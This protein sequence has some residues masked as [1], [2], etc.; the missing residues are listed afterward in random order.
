MKK[1]FIQL[2]VCGLLTLLLAGCGGKSREEENNPKELLYGIVPSEDGEQT[3]K[4][5]DAI[6]KY[7][8][9]TLNMPVKCI[10]ISNSSALIEA[11]RARKI[12]FASG[13]AFTYLVAAEKANAEP[14]IT[15]TATDQKIR[16]KRSCLVTYS[17]SSITIADLIKIPKKY[18]L[19]WAYPTSTTG[20][21]VPR[22]FL[23]QN[24]V[25][26]HHFKEV[27]TSTDHF[28]TVLT[29][30]SRKVDVAAI[31]YPTLLKFIRTKRIKEG[32]VKVIWES[33]PVAHA[34][35]FVRK[36][37]NEVLKKR[38]QQAYLR[39]KQDSPETYQVL[40]SQYEFDIEYVPASDTLYQ[41][42][43]EMANQIEG[44]KLE[45]E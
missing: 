14:I 42:L 28:A 39:L 36:D 4:R 1:W 20:H 9:R 33:G 17:G 31:Y 38:I 5:M 30:A 8:T 19:T 25:M 24:G 11:M 2:G 10:Q 13:G 16:Q 18:T 7:F 6:T 3:L 43:R 45:P 12:H 29:V 41:P 44:L 26:P 21:L 22:Y 15:T 34:P 32:A 35:V 23:Q 40:R 27:F 37:L